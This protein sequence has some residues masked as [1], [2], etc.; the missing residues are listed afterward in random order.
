[1]PES[2]AG[3]CSNLSWQKKVVFLSKL[4]KKQIYMIFCLCICEDLS[5]WSWINTSYKN[6][7]Y[8]KGESFDLC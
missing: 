6:K 8:L 1:M 3:L 2:E 4:W 5:C 7:I